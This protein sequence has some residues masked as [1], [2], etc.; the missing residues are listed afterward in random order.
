MIPLVDLSTILVNTQIHFVKSSM[1]S[2]RIKIFL[3]NWSD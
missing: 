1:I 3:G 2:G